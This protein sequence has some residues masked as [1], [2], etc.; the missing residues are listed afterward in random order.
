MRQKG[1]GREKN[2]EEKRER[3]SAKRCEKKK[4]STPLS[5]RLEEATF[6]EFASFK[7]L[8]MLSFFHDLKVCAWIYYRWCASP[9]SEDIY[10]YI[11]CL[12]ALCW[13]SYKKNCEIPSQNGSSLKR[14]PK[15][16]AVECDRNA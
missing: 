5:E 16:L 10:I 14:Q 11:I 9:N 1:R 12:T 4:K 15:I 3:G 2:K 8:R 13:T 6:A 7:G